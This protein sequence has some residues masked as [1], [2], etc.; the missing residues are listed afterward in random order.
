MR[1]LNNVMVVEYLQTALADLDSITDYYFLKFGMGSAEK[2]YNQIRG[3]IVH[4][5]DF[6]NS[7]VPA[8]DSM[9]RKLGY[10]EFY[11]GRFVAVYR[12]EPEYERIYIYH[13]ADTQMDYPHMYRNN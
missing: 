4:L 10:K 1:G 11:S 7:G 8:K 2:V 3:S 6:P 9:L 12:V 5:A 13:I